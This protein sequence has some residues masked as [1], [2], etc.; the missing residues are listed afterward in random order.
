MK[1]TTYKKFVIHFVGYPCAGKTTLEDILKEKINKVYSICYDKE[2]WQL[3]GYERNKDSELIKDITKGLFEVVCKM[4]NS[5]LLL[6]PTDTEEEY[7]FYKDIA[8][9]YGYEFISIELTAPQDV[10]IT[11]FRKR[12]KESREKNFPI[13]VTDENIFIQDLSKSFFTPNDKISFDTSV[14]KMEDIADEVIKL[15]PR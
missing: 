6:S 8:V 12:V 5:I 11:R 2:K 4:G 13:S 10:L 7:H 9:K 15:L 3:S 14:I 1:N